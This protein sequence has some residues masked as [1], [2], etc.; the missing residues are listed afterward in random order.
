[1][2]KVQ[3]Y[4][5]EFHK[6][7]RTDYDTNQELREKRDIILQKIETSLADNKRPGFERLMQGSY[8]MA[9]GVLPLGD[10]EYDI[11]VGLR[12]GFREDEHPS[13][14]VRKWVLAAVEGHTD[15][16]KSKGPC[17]RVR[18]ARGFH[19]DLVV[20][21]CWAEEGGKKTYRLGH[22]TNGW[23]P[24][25]PP[26]LLQFASDA[27]AR[28]KDTEGTTQTSQLRRAIRYLKRWSDIWQPEE[29]D[30]KPSGLAF[31]LLAIRH[32]SP[33]LGWDGKPDDLGAM[34]AL[35]DFVSGQTRLAETKPAPQ[36]ED[37]FARLSEAEMKK[38]INQFTTMRDALKLAKNETDPVKACEALVSMFGD[39][40]PVPPPEDTGAKTHAP[41]IVTSSSSG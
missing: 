13:T 38:L 15:D 9:T 11:D 14:E 7:I 32:L 40:F 31:T 3:K 2:A 17:I 33:S 34:L 35:A 39:D 10:R 25:D 28:F 18:Y 1:M 36:F 16:V 5:E 30:A 12:F 6:A 21:S 26:A 20:Y 24:A 8:A 4:F 27:Q 37:M 22:E 29:S 23:V 19:V 41:A